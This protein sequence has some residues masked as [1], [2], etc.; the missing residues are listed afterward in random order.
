MKYSSIISVLVA[1]RT[2]RTFHESINIHDNHYNISSN[3]VE[4]TAFFK[5]YN[6]LD[7]TIQVPNNIFHKIDF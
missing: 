5:Y 2:L 7:T 1:L 6:A 4:I 3:T